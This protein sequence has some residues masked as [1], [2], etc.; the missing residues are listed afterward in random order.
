MSADPASISR[1]HPLDQISVADPRTGSTARPTRL[2]AAALECPVH[3]SEIHEYPDEEGFWSVTLADDVREVSLDWKTYSSGRGVTGLT[4]LPARADAGDVHRHGPA[5]ARPDED[6][7]PARLHAEADRRARGRDPRDRGRVLDGVA[8]R[9]G[10]ELVNDVAQPAVSRVI[11]SFMGIP[12]K[13]DAAWAA[14]MNTTLGLGDPDLNPERD[15]GDD[16]EGDPDDLRALPGDDRRAAR[17]PDRRPDQRPRPRR[18]RG[19]A[20][21]RGR[22]RDGLLPAR[23]RRQ[24][25]DQGDLHERHAGADREPRAEAG[26]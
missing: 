6:A 21:D 13:D 9:G 22:D 18:G 23:R 15:R 19:R 1:S 25:L 8:D 26:C 7:L 12:E 20:A 10:C 3:W 2:P 4:N 14:L 16:R 5:Q 24:R 11:G 17:E